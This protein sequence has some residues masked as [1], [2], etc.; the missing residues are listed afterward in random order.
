MTG[1]IMEAGS[2]LAAHD[3]DG[4]RQLD[5]QEFTSFM[6]QFM[7]AAGFQLTEVLEEL[8]ILARTKVGYSAA[9]AALP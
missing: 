6:Q 7:A 9:A 4:D 8:V 3:V 5:F 1:L 2:V